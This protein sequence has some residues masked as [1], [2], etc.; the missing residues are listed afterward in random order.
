MPSNVT[1]IRAL[2]SSPSDVGNERDAVANAVSIWNAH[3]GPVLNARIELVRWEVHASPDMSG[4]AQEI[5]NRKLVDACDFGLAIFWSRVGTAT[6]RHVSGTVEEIERLR[7]AKKPVLL[8]FC[9]RPAGSAKS[10]Q[11]AKLRQLHTALRQ[12]G[13]VDYFD[14]PIT[15]QH[16]LQAHLTDVA[17]DVLDRAPTEHLATPIAS[18]WA[19]ESSSP[20]LRKWA[21]GAIPLPSREALYEDIVTLIGKTRGPLHVRATSTLHDRTTTDDDPFHEYVD[22]VARG[23]GDRARAG[24]PSSYTLVLSFMVGRDRLPPQTR[25]QSL[26][27][28]IKAFRMAGASGRSQF[29]QLPHF[30]YLDILTINEEHAFIGFPARANDPRLRYAVRVTGAEFTSQITQ[31]FDTCVLPFTHAINKSTLRVATR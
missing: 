11:S 19:A 25:R 6:A 1:E 28:R 26:R 29:F 14:E 30:G 10:R 18:A 27:Y 7:K 8:Y 22:A 12:R 20:S 4:Q 21:V 23:C 17:K 3:M 24:I 15:L 2:L 13:L 16:K 5:I 31:W 9:T